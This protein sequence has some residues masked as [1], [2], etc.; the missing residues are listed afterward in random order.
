LKAKQYFDGLAKSEKAKKLYQL[1]EEQ[2]KYEILFLLGRS[3]KSED[4]SSE[5]GSENEMKTKDRKVIR[6][7]LINENVIEEPSDLIIKKYNLKQIKSELVK[8]YQESIINDLS[9]VNG[10]KLLLL[11]NK[12]FENKE[13]KCEGDICIDDDEFD[14]IICSM[15]GLL[16]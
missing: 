8:K 14:A 13:V 7:Y 5:E 2:Q 1:L 4:T 10:D 3:K 15:T 9:I 11:F 16:A 6:D 12:V